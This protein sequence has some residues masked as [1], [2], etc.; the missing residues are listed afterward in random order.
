M[1]RDKS[2]LGSVVGHAASG[3]GVTVTIRAVSKVGVMD[4]SSVW[5]GV[6]DGVLVSRGVG[7]VS[8][9]FVAVADGV[10]LAE[11]VEVVSIRLEVVAV[12]R[13]R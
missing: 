1:F 3:A 5:V 9:H 10:S 7:D 11:M 4:G 8:I 6:G 12:T 13:I 2:R